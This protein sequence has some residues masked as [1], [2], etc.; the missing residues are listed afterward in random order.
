[1]D[2]NTSKLTSNKKK[3][4]ML[5]KDENGKMED[6]KAS[7]EEDNYEEEDTRPMKEVHE[8]S[9]LKLSAKVTKVDFDGLADG[10]AIR[11]YLTNIQ[12]RKLILVYGTTARGNRRAKQRQVIFH[13]T[14]EF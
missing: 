4:A 10:R 12:P 6:E 1:M 13:S 5:A 8:T 14:L 9:Q 2:I 11:H 7:D 3:I